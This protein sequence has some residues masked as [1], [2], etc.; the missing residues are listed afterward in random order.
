MGLVHF[1]RGVALVGLSLILVTPTQAQTKKPNI[2]GIMTGDNG[3]YNP[4]IY[5]RDDM[6]CQTRNIDRMGKEGAMFL[7]W[8]A[9]QILFC[10][11]LNIAYDSV[12]D[13]TQS[14]WIEASGGTTGA[15]GGRTGPIE[16]AGA[17][18]ASPLGS[19]LNDCL[20]WSTACFT[21]FAALEKLPGGSTSPPTAGY[22][23]VYV[24]EGTSANPILNDGIWLFGQQILII[25]LLLQDGLRSLQEMR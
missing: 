23:Q 9:Q 10:T 11:A 2:P 1:S 13:P 16:V 7:S 14:K 21:I 15:G 20:S 25:L 22:G 18:Y 12:Y 5:N 24:T 3:W 6:G 8:Y 19:D 4:S 17:K